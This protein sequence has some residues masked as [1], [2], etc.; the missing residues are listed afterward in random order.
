MGQY[1]RRLL[2]TSFTSALSQHEMALSTIQPADWARSCSYRRAINCASCVTLGSGEIVSESGPMKTSTRAKL[3]EDVFLR[4]LDARRT[5]SRGIGR[6]AIKGWPDRG[7]AVRITTRVQELFFAQL[8]ARLTHFVLQNGSDDTTWNEYTN[9]AKVHER[10]Q[11]CWSEHEEQ[12]LR[13]RDRAYAQIQSE[14]TA[15]QAIADPQSL[16]E[17]FR[18]A[19]RDPELIAA[20]WELDKTVRALDRELAL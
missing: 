17:P 15:L 16:E 7:A 3:V 13:L 11:E 12:T 9:T 10:L 5:F 18:M 14:I 19:R 6:C 1:T 4:C 2:P 8:S 20:A